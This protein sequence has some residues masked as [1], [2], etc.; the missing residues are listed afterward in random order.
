MRQLISYF[1]KIYTGRAAEKCL[2]P[3][4]FAAKPFFSFTNQYFHFECPSLQHSPA[5]I[6][7][8]GAAEQSFA[9]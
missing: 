6:H 5:K 2:V 4:C 7:I 3:V 1:C 9:S 8:A